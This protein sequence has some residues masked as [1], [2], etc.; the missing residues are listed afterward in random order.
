MF[1]VEIVLA[2]VH[3][4]SLRSRHLY[5]KKEIFQIDIICFKNLNCREADQFTY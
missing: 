4:A 2:T 5:W 3:L 1:I